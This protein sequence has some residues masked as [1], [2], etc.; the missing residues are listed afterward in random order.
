MAKVRLPAV[1]SRSMHPHRTNQLPPELQFGVQQSVFD[2]E[3]S[4]KYLSLGTSSSRKSFCD[5]NKL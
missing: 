1:G 5:L 2:C 3:C 4:S